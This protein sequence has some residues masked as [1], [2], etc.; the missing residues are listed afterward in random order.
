MNLPDERRRSR[1]FTLFYAVTSPLQVRDGIALHKLMDLPR[2]LA[3]CHADPATLEELA[4]QL[5]SVIRA[6]TP[7]PV[8]GRRFEELDERFALL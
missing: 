3:A 1:F 6:L 7:V 8:R 4:L 2:T 5:D